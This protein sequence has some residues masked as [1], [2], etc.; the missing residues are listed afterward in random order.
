M[1]NK[2]KLNTIQEAIEDIQQGKMVIVVDDEDRENEGDFVAAAEKV[3]PEMINFMTLY[4]RGL[5]CTPL[6][7][8]RCKELGLDMMVENNT[9]LHHTQFTVSI[10]LKGHGCTTGISVFDRAKTIQALVN[11]ATKPEDFGRPGH[12]FPLKAKEGGVLRRTGHTEAAVDL[13]R[14]AGLNPAGI[15][16]EIL[17]EDGS[18]AR[19]PQL[20]EIAKKHQMKIISIEDLVAYRM[21]NDRLINKK[22]DF[23]IET[24]YGQ[25]RLRAYEQTTNN[26]IHLAFTK[27]NWKE[28]EAVLTRVH[29]TFI[30]NNILE[31]IAKN[32]D[33]EL[34]RIFKKIAQ[35][36][37]GVVVVIS[38]E[39]YSLN[40][41]QRIQ[42]LKALQNGEKISLSKST[43]SKDFGIGAQI[44]HDLQISNMRLLTNSEPSRYVGMS[45]YGLEISEY[46]TY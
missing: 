8:S 5:L 7:E 40:L 6:L 28:N 12:I 14:L 30:S 36:G 22:E 41:L 32:Q 18:M 4:G 25:F 31:L 2:I 15:L 46:V 16:I 13:A 33:N 38:Q 21:R 29:S 37:K 45:G 26:Q 24:D 17:N 44:I 42:Q 35:E 9:V 19:L 27:G 20:M 10:D 1:E 23:T 39:D 34:D 43:E 3:T 11:S